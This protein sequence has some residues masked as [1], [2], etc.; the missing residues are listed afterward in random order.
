MTSIAFAVETKNTSGVPV[1]PDSLPA[2][3]VTQGSAIA[4]ISACG[5]GRYVVRIESD[6]IG[7]VQGV[8]S[9]A[10][11]S[12][13]NT[14]SWE[15]SVLDADTIQSGLATQASVDA[16][17]TDA[18]AIK[19]KTAQFAFTVANQVDANAL[20]SEVALSMS[21]LLSVSSRTGRQAQ[22]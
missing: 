6:D 16:I 13:G 18:T 1:A 8:V 5:V 14:Q 12:A 3:E 17:A 20:T 22:Q 19:A 7:T 9:W 2:I 11:A 21:Y 10:V 4:K 15:V